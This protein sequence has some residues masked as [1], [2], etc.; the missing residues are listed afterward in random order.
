MFISKC[1]QSV[2]IFVFLVLFVDHSRNYWLTSII[3]PLK[4]Q[5][6]IYT[7]S[8]HTLGSAWVGE[9]EFQASDRR[10]ELGRF[11]LN[12]KFRTIRLVHQM[13]RSISVKSDQNIRDQL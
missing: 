12:P 4:S 2:F 11:P 10:S 1:F 9:R 5:Y 6:T 13:E 7:S 8:N 3:L